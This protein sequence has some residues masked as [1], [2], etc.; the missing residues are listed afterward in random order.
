MEDA[1][2]RLRSLSTSCSSGSRLRL[3]SIEVGKGRGRGQVG[4]RH[5]AQQGEGNVRRGKVGGRGV[6]KE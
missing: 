5:L 1:G 4:K 6:E 2:C 3:L